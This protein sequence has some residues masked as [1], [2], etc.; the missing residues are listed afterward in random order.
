MERASKRV[1]TNIQAGVPVE[2]RNHDEAPGKITGP[3]EQGKSL[4]YNGQS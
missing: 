1:H 3:T 4:L 2:D